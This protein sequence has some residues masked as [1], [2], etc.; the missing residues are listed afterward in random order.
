MHGIINKSVDEAA[1]FEDLEDDFR[2]NFSNVLIDQA[3]TSFD[4]RFLQLTLDRIST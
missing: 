2:I 1:P 4:G 3:I